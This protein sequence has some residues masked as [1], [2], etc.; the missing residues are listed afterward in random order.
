MFADSSTESKPFLVLHNPG[1]LLSI[2]IPTLNEAGNLAA[3]FDD[4]K[5]QQEISFEIII[6][7]GGSTD[8]TRS[9]A[10]SFGVQWVSAQ[11]GRGAQM[12]AAAAKATG[13]YYLFLHADSRIDDPC[14][15]KEAVHALQLALPENLRVAGHFCLRFLRSTQRN[16]L[17]YRYLEEKTVCNRV[18]TTNGDQ[19]LLLAQEFFHQLG[20]F[21]Q[22]LPFL[23]DQRIAESIRSQGTWIT[24]PG[25]L[26]TSARRFEVEGFHRRYLLMGMM[27]AFHAI[28]MN[29]F[30]AA[31]PGIYRVQ[32]ETGKL[33]LYPFFSRIWQMIR[34]DWGLAE[35]I[36]TFYALGRKV[37]QNSWQMFFFLDVWLRPLWGARRYPLLDFH[38]QFFARCNP[39]RLCNALA[40]LLCFIW[41]M[42]IL[43]PFFWLSEMKQ[44]N[45]T[46]CKNQHAQSE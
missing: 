10:D 7:D 8:A 26:K 27:M 22:S 38:D 37:C 16:P 42:L 17:A 45:V 2:I 29:S 30:F 46:H 5:R 23:E 21:D 13:A 35:S 1:V 25:Y 44:R 31:A 15:L 32:Q 3:L 39:F 14:L 43:T 9:V 12:N 20:G 24:L 33:L 40:G 11:R 19:G 41:F 36:R 6:G 18:N 34:Y 28:G 4:L